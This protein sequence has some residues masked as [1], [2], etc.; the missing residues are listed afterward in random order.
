MVCGLGGERDERQLL[1]VS[2]STL[3]FGGGGVMTELCLIYE[4][5]DAI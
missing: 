4:L 5:Y 1:F 2:S 3:F